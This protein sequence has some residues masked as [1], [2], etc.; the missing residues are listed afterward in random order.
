[1]ELR[2]VLIFGILCSLSIMYNN[3]YKYDYGNYEIS[4]SMAQ[5]CS[6]SMKIRDEQLCELFR[7][8]YTKPNLEDAQ[9][10]TD[11]LEDCL[12]YTSRCV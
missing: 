7:K 9:N 2:A 1:M 6:E 5:N 8:N 12:L 3:C 11:L 4:E 10:L